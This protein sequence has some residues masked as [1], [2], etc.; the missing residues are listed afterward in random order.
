MVMLYG[1]EAEALQDLN[2]SPGEIDANVQASAIAE[3][4]RQQEPKDPAHAAGGD[5]QPL[6]AR[7]RLAARRQARR[8]GDAH[9]RVRR[10]RRAAGRGDAHSTTTW[11]SSPSRSCTSDRR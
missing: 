2:D 9:A 7:P 11:A 8:G 5:A 10:R 4:L 1:R 3:A 6:R